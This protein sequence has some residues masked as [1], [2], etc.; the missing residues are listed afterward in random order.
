M[1]MLSQLSQ[2]YGYQS[3]NFQKPDEIASTYDDVKAMLADQKAARE[4]QAKQI[5]S[6]GL[7]GQAQANAETIKAKIAQLQAMQAAEQNPA[8]K[9]TLQAQIE[10]AMAQLQKIQMQG[11]EGFADPMR[12]IDRALTP[13]GDSV[14]MLNYQERVN[15]QKQ[16]FNE[17]LPAQKKILQDASGYSERIQDAIANSKIPNAEDIAAYRAFYRQFTDL[18]ASIGSQVMATGRLKM[19]SPEDLLKGVRDIYG[20]EATNAALSGEGGINAI[21]NELNTSAM[22][23]ISAGNN[24]TQEQINSLVSDYADK[25]AKYDQAVLTVP[26]AQRSSLPK[27]PEIT[28]II[29]RIQGLKQQQ[30]A[31]QAT[32]DL[33]ASNTAF[34]QQMAKEANAREKEKQAISTTKSKGEIKEKIA[35]ILTNTR[36]MTDAFN[37][38]KNAKFDPSSQIARAANAKLVIQVKKAVAPDAM[39]GD[40]YAQAQGTDVT[41]FDAIKRYAGV[42]SN[43]MMDEAQATQAYNQ[44]YDA[45]KILYD[46]YAS[47]L[48]DL[49]YKSVPKFPPKGVSSAPSFK[50]E[51]SKDMSNKGGASAPATKP[52]FFSRFKK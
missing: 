34:A 42:S 17:I 11:A 19:T 36:I 51:P 3:P 45:N 25:K 33:A 49:G 48:S 37:E 38:V 50:D 39:T 28:D 29:G 44:I 52:G 23:L 35:S 27:A 13:Q 10:A 47:E 5:I 41:L 9:E 6:Q 46:I 40:E 16:Y 31:T 15:Q 20:Q 2:R 8:T 21:V 18:G 43:V 26:I 24:A 30:Q 14:G 32:R 1:Q 12:A 4:A 22:K 7:L